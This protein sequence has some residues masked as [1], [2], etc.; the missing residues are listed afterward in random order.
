MSDS[1]AAPVADK[2]VL[3]RAI[4]VIVSPAATFAL[5]ASNPR[6]AGIL[7]LVCLVLGLAAG[8]PQFSEKVR[9]SALDMQIQ[10]MERSGQTLPPQ[11]YANMER[12]SHFSAYITIVSMFIVLPIFSLLFAAVYWA[13]FNAILGGTA[14]FKQVLGVVTHSQ[15]IG[16]LGA[17]AAIPL[18][19]MQGIQTMAGPYNLGALAPMLEPNSMVA[20]FL[21]RISFFTLW[22]L[23]V[24]AIGLG[25]L[26]RR[27]STGIAIGLIAIYV[28]LVGGFTMAFPSLTGR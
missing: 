11:A 25:V 16:A 8:G 21:S 26:Y 1:I 22:G 2:G 20:T 5:V 14:S 7:L 15:V 6:P 18:V 10:Q 27:K 17:I 24:T 3:S 12:F 28:L 4:G 23:V 9:Q 13:L 19:L